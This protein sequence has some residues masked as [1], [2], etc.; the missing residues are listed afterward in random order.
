MVAETRSL[1]SDGEG[2]NVS[3]LVKVF[4]GVRQ[5]SPFLRANVLVSSY[6][7]AASLFKEMDLLCGNMTLRYGNVHLLFVNAAFLPEVTYLDQENT[8]RC[9]Y[10]LLSC[11]DLFV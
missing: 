9:L 4:Y 8:N 1:F 11:V 10:V 6:N 3:I 7:K 5:E 2:A